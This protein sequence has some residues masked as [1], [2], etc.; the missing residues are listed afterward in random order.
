VETNDE[1]LSGAYVLKEANC[2]SSTCAA[3]AS[4][5]FT[6]AISQSVQQQQQQQSDSDFESEDDSRHLSLDTPCCALDADLS[7]KLPLD[8]STLEQTSPA[9]TC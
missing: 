2:N 1:A 6:R 4:L 8:E 5:C 3:A 9:I 7:E